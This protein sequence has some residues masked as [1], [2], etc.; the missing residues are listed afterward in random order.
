MPAKPSQSLGDQFRTH[1]ILLTKAAFPDQS[2]GGSAGC[3]VSVLMPG[4]LG[5]SYPQDTIL[6]P[7]FYSTRAPAPIA[8]PPSGSS[9]SLSLL[10]YET[11]SSYPL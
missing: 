11:A 10:R 8:F 2:L 3:W 5:Y 9:Y 4:F 6:S 1:S 7:E